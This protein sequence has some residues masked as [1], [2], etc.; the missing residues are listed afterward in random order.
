MRG[1]WYQTF[2]DSECVWYWTGKKGH[3]Y[4]VEGEYRGTSELIPA[5]FY[6][7]ERIPTPGWA[8]PELRVPE[9]L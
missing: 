5:Q 7:S 8:R 1:Q 9:G 3:W 6:A 4:S 2:G